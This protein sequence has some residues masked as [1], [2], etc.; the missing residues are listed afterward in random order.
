MKKVLYSI[1]ALVGLAL[2]AFVALYEVNTI[3]AFVTIPAEMTNIIA[4]VLTYGGLALVALFT[5]L[6]FSGKGFFR[7]LLFILTILVVALAV[8]AFGFPNLIT[9]ILG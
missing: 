4:Y 1:L 8:I 5:L 9:S 6:T 2:L 3:H 7:V